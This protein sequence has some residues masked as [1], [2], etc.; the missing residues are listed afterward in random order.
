MVLVPWIR[1]TGYAL[2]SWMLLCKRYAAGALVALGGWLCFNYW[3]AGDPLAF[4]RAQKEFGMPE[5][6]LL[7]GFHYTAMEIL[8]PPG[9][10]DFDQYVGSLGNHF[11]PVLYFAGLI[12]LS[13]WL[14]RRAEYL[15]ALTVLSTVLLSHYQAFW[16]GAMRY[17]LRLIPFLSL[18]LLSRR[19]TA[20]SASRYSTYGLY[21]V[22]VL[23]PF[24]LQIVFARRF[25]TGSW[26]F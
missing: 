8:S 24:V 20:S 11:L 21:G 19:R 17:D 7:K 3:I 6:S 13:V 1:L 10:L 14:A 4:L 2:A 12:W 26:A 23:L 15:L 18:P 25:H 16:R 5:G 22:F 9:R